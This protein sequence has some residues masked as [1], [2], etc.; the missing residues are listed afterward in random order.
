ME[1]TPAPAATR[2]R[3]GPKPVLWRENARTAI[4]IHS[5]E[6]REK[7]LCDGLTFN[8]GDACAYSCE[9]CYVKAS[10]WKVD[11]EIVNGHS[12]KL[13]LA[14][15]NRL[16]FHDVVI[17]RRNAV[18]LVKRQLF[19]KKGRPRFNN[20]EDTRV[21]YSST[22]VDV[23]ANMIL[24]RETAD[25]CNRILE[26]TNWQIRLLSKSSIFHLLIEKDLIPE[27]YHQRLIFG[28]ST[29]TLNDRVAK[30]IEGGTPPVTKRLESLHWLQD[31]GLRTFG[32]ICPSLPQSNYDT[33]SKA[34]C[35]AIR[36]EKCEHVWAEV[37]NV[38]GKSL[39]RTL[40]GLEREGLKDEAELIKQ[41]SKK[42]APAWENYARET[43]LAH[44][45]TLQAM[46][47]PAEKLRFL[48]YIRRG[49]ESW[50]AEQQTAGAILLGKI[51][52]EH[53]LNQ[54][55][56]MTK[57]LPVPPPL[58]PADQQYLDEREQLVAAGLK[59]SIAASKALFEIAT[60][61]DGRLW[62]ERFDSFEDYCRIK[63]GYQK[64][65]AY[66]LKNCGE[67]VHE[68]ESLP[69]T[70]QYPKGYYLP[71]AETHV[72]AVLE[73][74]KEE[75]VP[76]WKELVAETPPA[77]LTA[78]VVRHEVIEHV[79][80][81]D[82]EKFAKKKHRPLSDKRRAA[83]ALEKLKAAI[84][85]LDAKDKITGLLDKVEELIKGASTVK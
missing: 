29:G 39:G 35:A 8:L 6:F 68:L 45:R 78:K 13:G 71:L 76:F 28:F 56:P 41:V 2:E 75:Q 1:T 52:K 49:S 59:A 15:P 50:W 63:W 18:E 26:H 47:V 17:R 7:K 46:K 55:P 43:F 9:F 77:D 64:Q 81:T 20:P 22:L 83:I 34:I 36:I 54:L 12:D 42:N 44:T 73:L 85:A 80:E 32:M 61:G 14:E 3:M 57:Y 10:M 60:Y 11:H 48:Q 82:P 38:R 37:I 66:R 84:E 25:A 19:N 58:A 74:P 69:A 40:A 27:K 16:D 5:K 33:F 79:K 65:H 70:K 67:F 23:A 4:N 31:R 30:A 62:K 51:A 24:L 21:I 53:N 72:R